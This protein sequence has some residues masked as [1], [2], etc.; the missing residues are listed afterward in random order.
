MSWATAY[1]RGAESSLFATLNY[2]QVPTHCWVIE[3][4]SLA[5]SVIQT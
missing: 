2:Y 1:D 4:S 5:P 3:F